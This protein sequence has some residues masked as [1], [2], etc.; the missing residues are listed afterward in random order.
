MLLVFLPA[1]SELCVSITFPPFKKLLLQFRSPA[2][3]GINGGK[4]G[5]KQ[6]SH[7]TD[8]PQ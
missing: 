6:I 3:S 8:H 7:P 2:E 1:N 5:Y 4:G